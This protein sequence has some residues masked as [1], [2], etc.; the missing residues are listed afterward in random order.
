MFSVLRV[1]SQ[2]GIML[3]HGRMTYIPTLP[4]Y[5]TVMVDGA[6]VGFTRTTDAEAV[7]AALRCSKVSKTNKV[8]LNLEIAYVPP[9]FKNYGGAFPGIYVFSTPSRMLRPVTQHPSGKIEQIG[10]LEQAFMHI[11]C[12]DGENIYQ[13][14]THE[15]NGPGTVL[16]VV[17][18]CTP[19]SD[20]NQS[21]RNHVSVP[22]G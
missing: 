12:Q 22:D 21:P 11:R 10:S 20:F 3:V 16:S 6:V 4:E 15:E 1:L 8:S 17:A 2:V 19:W 13:P 5:L 14:H 18:S 7:V 9:L